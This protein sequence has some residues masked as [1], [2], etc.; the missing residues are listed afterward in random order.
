MD[1]KIDRE[2][3]EK[4]PPLTEEEFKQLRENILEDGEVYEPIIVWHGVIVD[5]HNRYRVIKEHPEIPYRVKQMDF[6]DKWA[7]FDWMYKKQLGRRNLTEEQKDYLLGKMYEA[8]KNTRGGDR[9]SDDFSKSH[10]GTLKSGEVKKTDKDKHG[11][12]GELAIEMNIGRNTVHR[13][14]KFAKGVDAIR[15]VSPAAAEK[16]LEGKAGVSK[17]TIQELP[18]RTDEE[19]AEVARAI[20][21]DRPIKAK[22]FPSGKEKEL[23]GIVPTICRDRD[24][25]PVEYELDDLLEEI[26]CVNE[27]CIRNYQSIMRMHKAMIGKNAAEVAKVVRELVEELEKIEEEM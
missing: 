18:K 7:A 22:P 11:I 2:F 26:R 23:P 17:A 8:R 13:A 15:A 27:Q 14:A 24:A 5:G 4:I 16:I 3:Q 10:F 25:P 12:S 9:R 21:E 6:A 1:L 19:V 20:E